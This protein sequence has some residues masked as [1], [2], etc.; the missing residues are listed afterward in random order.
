MEQK[1]KKFYVEW[2]RI[3]RSTLYGLIALVVISAGLFFGIRWVIDNEMFANPEL[4]DIPKDAAR[5]ISFEGDVRI[6]RAATRETVVVTKQMYAAAGDTLQTQADGRATIQMIDGSVYTIRPNSTV[7]IR[8]NSSLFGGR[9]VRVALDDGQL[10]VRTEEQPENTRNVVE[11]LDSETRL[12]GQTDAS[13]NADPRSQGSEIRISRG[14]V[15]TTVGGRSTTINENEFAALEKG[16]ISSR[17]NLL[18]PPRTVGPANASQVVDASGRGA[19]VTFIW[20][21]EAPGVVSYHLQVARTPYFSSDSMLV[22]RGSISNREYRLAGLTPGTYH[23]RLKAV[24]RSGQ[25]S[26]W[27][28]P[29]RLN[30]VRAT[31]SPNITVSDWSVERLGGDVYLVSGK[32]LPGLVIR[33][34]GREVFSGSDGTFRFQTRSTNNELSIEAADDRGNRAGFVISLSTARVVRRF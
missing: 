19:S 15:E 13:F 8:D 17:E 10:N 11:M 30:V 3:R 14:S 1:Y 32:T 6:T 20:Q 23:W 7:I 33:Y 16:K 28:E 31:A 5:I 12:R 4:G 25:A 21:P 29:A 9:N 18:R 34:Q 24:A 26:E 2:W 22:D 27:S